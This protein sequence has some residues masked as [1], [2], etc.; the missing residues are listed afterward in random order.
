MRTGAVYLLLEFQQANQKWEEYG[1]WDGHGVAIK[2]KGTL[3]GA[4]VA[5]NLTETGCYGKKLKTG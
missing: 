3:A 1:T 2:N 4:F 5:F